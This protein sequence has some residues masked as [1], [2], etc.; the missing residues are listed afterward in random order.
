[1]SLSLPP[2]TGPVEP[3]VHGR[4]S[5]VQLFSLSL[6]ISLSISFSQY[7]SQHRSPSSDPAV[8][9]SSQPSRGVIEPGRD[10]EVSLVT[11]GG[12]QADSSAVQVSDKVQS[13]RKRGRASGIIRVSFLLKANN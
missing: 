7:I 6:S 11:A 2:L 12:L 4:S 8:V 3:P 5:Q 9:V 10:I 1:M 13:R